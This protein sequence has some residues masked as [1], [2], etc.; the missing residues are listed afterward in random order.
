MKTSRNSWAGHG[1]LD[2]ETESEEE[3]SDLEQQCNKAKSNSRKVS[4]RLKY[5]LQETWDSGPEALLKGLIL[6]IRFCS[7]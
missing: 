7:A 1:E 4:G 6:T 2:S 5:E 3:E